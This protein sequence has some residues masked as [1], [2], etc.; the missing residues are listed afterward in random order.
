[1][2]RGRSY[3]KN[4]AEGTCWQCIQSMLLDSL[5]LDM[6]LKIDILRKQGGRLKKEAET[7]AQEDRD[8]QHCADWRSTIISWFLIQTACVSV[9]ACMWVHEQCVS[10]HFFSGTKAIV[11]SVCLSCL[12]C[13]LSV[14]FSLTLLYRIRQSLFQVGNPEVSNFQVGK[15]HS[16]RHFQL[17]ISNFRVGNSEGKLLTETFFR[18]KW[19]QD[20]QQFVFLKH[21]Y[22]IDSALVRSGR[23]KY[24]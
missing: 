16:L 15:T 24:T 11:S 3:R 2:H 23:L 12:S 9:C 22:Y 7:N 10:L 5:G 4:A 17:G 8:D 18:L 6:I 13:P 1:M 14:M 20:D 19:R 21:M